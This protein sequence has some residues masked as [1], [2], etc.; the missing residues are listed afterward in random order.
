MSQYKSFAV[1]AGLALAGLQGT[2]HAQQAEQAPKDYSVEIYGLLIPFLDSAQTTGASAPGTVGSSMVP[3][4]SYTGVNADRRG[5]LTGG[6]TNIGFRGSRNLGPDM[7]ALFQIES[8]IPVDGDPGPNT[9]ASRN[10]HV[11]LQGKWGTAFL[12][13]W[14]TPYKWIALQTG[15]LR[16]LTVAD[17][18]NT[19]Q[20]PGFRVPVTTTQSGRTNTSADAAFNRRQGNSIQYWSPKV[21]GFSGRLAYS[22]GE[23]KTSASATTPSTEPTLFSGSAEYASGPLILRYAYEQHRDYF[24]LSAIAGPAANAFNPAPALAS[25]ISNANPS[26]RDDGNQFV[27]IYQLGNVKLSGGVERLRYRNDDSTAAK[28]NEYKRDSWYA[29]VQPRFGAHQVWGMYGKALKG[30][31]TLVGGGDCS[32]T[33]LGA[34]EY[35][36]GYS[37]DFMKDVTFFAQAYGVNND[38][39]ASYGTFPSAPAGAAGNGATAV[40]ASTR[41]VGIG[42]QFIF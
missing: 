3:A 12:G 27:A 33:G 14:D 37:Y 28:L 21:G 39:S 19:I 29:I 22:V 38:R 26:S 41:G 18:S 1:A 31:C 17:Y 32:T 7:K 36:V 42:V 24:G 13:I 11:G 8:G 40:G 34:S 20:T 23:G 9:L 6:T 10:T 35:A 16:G 5:R 2:A 4:S 15:F 25:G 30:N